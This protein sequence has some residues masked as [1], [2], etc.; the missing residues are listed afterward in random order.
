[1][2]NYR[3]RSV[4]WRSRALTFVSLAA[5]LIFALLGLPHYFGA[6]S[7]ARVE[8]PRLTVDSTGQNEFLQNLQFK[9]LV[10]QGSRIWAA[11]DGY[12]VLYT[13]TQVRTG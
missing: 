8:A 10:V 7:A 11:T 6:K 3:D 2:S 1:M 5:L 12:G 13:T 4:V 9:Q